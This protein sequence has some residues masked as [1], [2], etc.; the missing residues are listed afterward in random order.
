MAGSE[1]SL[2][3]RLPNKVQNID[4]MGRVKNDFESKIAKEG[5]GFFA[6]IRKWNY[7]RQVKKFEKHDVKLFHKGTRSE[8]KVR[9][10][11]WR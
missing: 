1:R 3:D 7:K 4:Y 11:N 6:G 5:E 10:R 8:N 9:A 2:L